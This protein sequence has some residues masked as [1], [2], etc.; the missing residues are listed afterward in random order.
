[1]ILL[2]SG[3]EKND[4]MLMLHYSRRAKGTLSYLKRVVAIKNMVIIELML[5]NYDWC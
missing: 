4:E 1:M 2:R 3:H 5:P